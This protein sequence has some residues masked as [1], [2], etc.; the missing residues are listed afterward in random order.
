M[1]LNIVVDTGFWFAL[2]SKSDK[3][4]KDALSIEKEILDGT[5]NL[6]IPWPTLYETI[7]TKFVKKIKNREEL[8]RYIEHPNTFKIDDT[9][10]RENA[11]ESV[12]DPLAK[13]NFSAVDYIIRGILED[14][15]VKTDALIT[16]NEKDFI[17][18]C[19]K[20]DI[21]IIKS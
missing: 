18:I 3:Y 17:D 15:N 16:F 20:N 21:E 1:S 2:F 7:N 13:Q 14:P 11:I 5:F 4:H 8:K 19:Y 6:L 9:Q 12:I 10:Y